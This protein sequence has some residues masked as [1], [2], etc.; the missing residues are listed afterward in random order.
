MKTVIVCDAIH[1]VGFEILNAQKDIKVIDAV[2]TPR[3]IC[4]A[5]IPPVPVRA[6]G[7]LAPWV[8]WYIISLKVTEDDLNATVFTFAI[9]LPITSIL[10]WC[11]FK[12]ATPEYNDLIIGHFLLA[13]GCKF[14]SSVSP[15]H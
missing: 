6:F 7:P 13:E 2:D 11:V 8:V 1:P 12:P 10:D 4:F 9:L 14:V 3:P 5:L 15:R